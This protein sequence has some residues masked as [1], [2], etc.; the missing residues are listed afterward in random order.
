MMNA[1]D[2][3]E[4]A[5][6]EILAMIDERLIE[7]RHYNRDWDADDRAAVLKQRNRVAKLFNMKER[8]SFFGKMES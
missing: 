7:D 5:K 8:K 1:T 3:R 4:W 6:E 2:T